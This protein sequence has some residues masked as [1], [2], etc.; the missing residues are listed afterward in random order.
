LI[1]NKLLCALRDANEL[2]NERVLNVHEQYPMANYF[3][4]PLDA[5]SHIV[6]HL[7]VA[8]TVLSNNLLMTAA[9]VTFS[10]VF[11]IEKGA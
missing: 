4:P 10:C 7:F 6:K 9:L 8:F 1:V 2:H 11:M 5:N 3:L